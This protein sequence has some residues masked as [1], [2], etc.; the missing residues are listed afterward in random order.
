M[1]STSRHVNLWWRKLW[2]IL[3]CRNIPQI[4]PG[5]GTLT[6]RLGRIGFFFGQ[7]VELYRTRMQSHRWIQ[8]GE[9]IH[10]LGKTRGSRSR[11]LRFGSHIATQQYCYVINAFI[12]WISC[13]LAVVMHSFA[14]MTATACSGQPCSYAAMQLCSHA[15]IQ[16]WHQIFCDMRHWSKRQ[17]L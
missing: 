15:F 13:Q 17:S 9:E 7:A 14:C 8:N 12:H 2:W 11:N 5:T 1:L 16:L 4:C 6:K 10:R 3:L